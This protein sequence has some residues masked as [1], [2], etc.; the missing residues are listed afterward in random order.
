MISGVIERAKYVASFVDADLAKV[1]LKHPRQSATD[2]SQCLDAAI[3][4][5][6]RAQDATPDGGV[7]RSFGFVYQPFFRCKGWVASYPETTGY[8]IPTMFDY[9]RESGRQDLFDRA[10]RMAD[11]ECDVQMANGAVQG[12]TVAQPA[13]PAVFNTGQVIFGWVRAYQ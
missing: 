2:P 5:I 13:S 7:A 4:W 3:Q 10:V 1:Y 12:G 8:I 9:A 11:W 6:C